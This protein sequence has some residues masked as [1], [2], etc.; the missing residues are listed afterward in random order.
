MIDVNLYPFKPVVTDDSREFWNGCNEGKLLFQRCLSCGES[1]LPPSFLCSNCLSAE[2]E[3]IESDGKGIIYS[4]V[5]YHRAF[6]R[7][8]EDKVPY[9]VAAIDLDEGVRVLSNII[10]SDIHSLECDQ[11]VELE[12]VEIR[13][14][15]FLPMFRVVGGG[16]EDG[17]NTY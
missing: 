10:E 6:H 4:F 8:L 5:V 11:K 1:R 17:E 9:V 2:Y 15:A 13:E 16:H 7:F 12:F 14:D 3:W